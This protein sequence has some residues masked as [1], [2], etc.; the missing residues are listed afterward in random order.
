MEEA[1][2]DTKARAKKKAKTDR[3]AVLYEAV[4]EEDI[5]EEARDESGSEIE[6]C[7]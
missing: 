5:E 1:E 7:I 3:R 4:S 2:L 6:D